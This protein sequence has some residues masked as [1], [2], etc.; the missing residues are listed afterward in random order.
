M[1]VNLLANARVHT[2]AGSTVVT[3][4]RAD[5]DAVTLRVTDDGPGIPPTLRERL[6]QRV[7]RGDEARSPGSGSTGL[8]LAIVD[9]VVRAHGGRV[10]VD[11]TPGATTSTVT[12]PAAPAS[13][14]ASGVVAAPVS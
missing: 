7:V 13:A 2:P 3:S 4:V 1:L 6:F 14:R 10:E 9:A 8:G 11:G 12:L 5:G